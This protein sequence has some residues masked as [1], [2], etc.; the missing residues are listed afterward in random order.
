ML[1]DPI[2]ERDVTIPALKPGTVAVLSRDGEILSQLDD[3]LRRLPAQIAVVKVFGNQIPRQRNYAVEKMYGEW[4][5]FVDAD[6][7]PP[8]DGLIKLQESEASICVGVCH[9]R[10]APFDLCLTKSLEPPARWTVHEIPRRGLLHVVAAGTG[11]MMIQRR[12]FAGMSR[13]YFRCGQIALD[14]LAEDTEFCLRASEAGFQT[15][16]ECSV[17]CGH[18]VSGIMRPGMDGRAWIEWP[19]PGTYV[20]P[21]TQPD[22]EPVSA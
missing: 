7:V 1:D 16:V 18:R 19:G 14:I 15:Y 4:L 17:R 10:F 5:C 13:P 20:L 9:E 2:I 8:D 6:I 3:W 21:L 12:V 11:F 22:R